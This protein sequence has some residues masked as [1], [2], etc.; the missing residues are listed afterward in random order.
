MAATATI[1]IRLH[2]ERKMSKVESEYE[3][4][5]MR[6]F[7]ESLGYKVRYE[8]ITLRLPGG[9]RYTPDF[10]V[11]RVNAGIL[12]VETKGMYRLGSAGRSHM[13]FNE[14]MAAF[15]EYAFR[16]AQKTPS[17]WIT[18]EGKKGFP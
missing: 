9:S 15:P 7:P 1:G 4:L 6:E 12:M 5:L 2:K 8:T 16:F 18:K 13:A 10:T 17:G 11:F 14:A 3:Q